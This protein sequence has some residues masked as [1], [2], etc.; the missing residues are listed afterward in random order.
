M[1]TI[2]VMAE[3]EKQTNPGSEPNGEYNA[4]QQLSSSD[5]GTPAAAAQA[6]AAAAS[7][8]PTTGKPKSKFKRV[9]GFFN[10]YLLTFLLLLVIA[11]IVFVVS[12]LNSQ[13][14]PIIPEAALQ[15]LTQETLNQIA[16]GDSSV[17]DPRYVL[18]V[19]SDAV[20]A[21]DA[22]IRGDLSVAGN[23]QL[24]QALTIPTLTVS[25]NTNLAATQISGLSVANESLLRGKVTL[26]N[27]LDV[28]G[29][30]N[31]GGSLTASSI[32]T[33]SL[34]LGGNGNLV[35]NNHISANGPTPNRSQ[36][37]AAG[38]GGST[39]ISGSDLAGTLNVNTGTGTS[40]GCFAT[41]TFRQAYTNTPSVLVTPV[42]AA[43]AQTNFY[44]TRS[45]TEF[46]IC[47][48]NAAPTGQNFAYDYFVIN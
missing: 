18:N 22:L 11:G 27:G 25:G 4:L 15:E 19:Q 45:S 39:S 20:F 7:I 38:S 9:L 10:V 21:G 34:T 5:D 43:A 48:T 40:P 47:T 23:I 6:A 13:K 17:G 31:F 28:S 30:V 2:R 16:T 32:T 14:E 29:S 46:S 24:G 42:G 44:V 26:Q 35:L 37:G 1:I 8:D 36:G 41:I 12:Y 33:G 3:E